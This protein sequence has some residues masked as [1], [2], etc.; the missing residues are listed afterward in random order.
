MVTLLMVLWLRIFHV[1]TGGGVCELK[2]AEV[3]EPSCSGD[4]SLEDFMKIDQF[5]GHNS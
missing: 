2:R 1:P 3:S 5:R 4:Q